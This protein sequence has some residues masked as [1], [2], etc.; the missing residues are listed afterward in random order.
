MAGSQIGRSIRQF[1][2]ARYGH[3]CQ[4]IRRCGPNR[5]L[6]YEWVTVSLKII[7]LACTPH[8]STDPGM[9]TTSSIDVLPCLAYMPAERIGHN[10]TPGSRLSP[11]AASVPRE[12]AA[13]ELRWVSRQDN[14]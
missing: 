4:C 11:V 9:M 13:I 2:S 10:N 7:V 5:I 12:D 8:E 14:G 6:S 1:A 3:W